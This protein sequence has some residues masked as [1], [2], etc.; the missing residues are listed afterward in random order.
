MTPEKSKILYSH[1]DELKDELECEIEQSL[2]RKNLSQLL[3]A[4][5]MI[6][7]FVEEQNET[8]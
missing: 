6:K 5:I 2:M 3:D 8:R 1:L 7:E 4:V